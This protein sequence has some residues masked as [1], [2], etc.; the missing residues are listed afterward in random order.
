M[1]KLDKLQQWLKNINQ[2]KNLEKINK[3]YLALQR[4]LEI[5]R[6]PPDLDDFFFG[7]QEM[8]ILIASEKITSLK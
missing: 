2:L 5:F 3:W 1:R 8:N 6:L 7:L 4:A